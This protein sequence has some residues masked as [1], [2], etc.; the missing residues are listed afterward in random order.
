MKN[1]G[2]TWDT[3]IEWDNEI[4]MVQRFS[5]KYRGLRHVNSLTEA[6]LIKIEKDIRVAQKIPVQKHLH[7]QDFRKGTAIGKNRAQY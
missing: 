1:S 4:S 3:E 5:G 7:K 6:V 2:S